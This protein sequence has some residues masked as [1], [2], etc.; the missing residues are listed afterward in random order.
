MQDMLALDAPPIHFYIMFKEAWEKLDNFHYIL[1]ARCNGIEADR[2]TYLDAE[3]KEHAI[4]AG[5]VVIAAGMKFFLEYSDNLL[6]LHSC[7][8]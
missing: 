2:V 1:Q 5:S 4:E 8:F 3:D 7:S 6:L